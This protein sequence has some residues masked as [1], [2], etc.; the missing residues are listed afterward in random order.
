V[1]AP[2]YFYVGVKKFSKF[3]LFRLDLEGDNFFFQSLFVE[4]FLKL[5]MFLGNGG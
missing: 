5:S 1:F 4:E 3:E 2:F